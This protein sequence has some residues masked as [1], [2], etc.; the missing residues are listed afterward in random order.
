MKTLGQ[1]RHLRDSHLSRSSGGREL[2]EVMQVFGPA[3]IVALRD[4]RDGPPLREALVHLL[5]RTFSE[6]DNLSKIAAQLEAVDVDLQALL[7][8]P[9]LRGEPRWVERFTRLAVS[10]VRDHLN[11]GRRR[12]RSF[13]DRNIFHHPRTIWR[14]V[15]LDCASALAADGVSANDV[16]EELGWLPAKASQLWR[17]SRPR[18]R[19]SWSNPTSPVRGRP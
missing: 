18:S 4:E 5:K 14:E 16:R 1:L 6:H 9:S 10:F 12:R 2:I 3:L 17:C 19:C 15:S 7:S 11:H 8:H 13:G